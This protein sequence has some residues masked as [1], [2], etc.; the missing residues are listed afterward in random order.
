M[1]LRLREWQKLKY[2]DPELILRGLR[3][4]ALTQPLHTLP[5]EVRTLRRRDLRP[6]GEGRQAALFCYGMSKV[7]G[8]HVSFA[9]AEK[10]DY[11]IVARYVDGGTIRYVPVQL[12]ELVP[13]SVNPSADLQVELDKISKYADC[14]DLVVAFHLNGD[15]RMEFSELRVPRESIAELWFFGA[16]APDQRKWL[17]I[18]DML[19]EERYWHEF[20]YPGA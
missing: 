6:Y 2:L 14:R 20:E 4:I 18:G 5:Y 11:D 16:R 19:K 10:S 8:R 3:N 1:D 17:L 9:Q 13:A 12:K 7:F 15:R